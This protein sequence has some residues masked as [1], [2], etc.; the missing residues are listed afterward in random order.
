MDSEVEKAL[1]GIKSAW[2][3]L[4]TA[5]DKDTFDAWSKEQK[6]L[7]SILYREKRKLY[8]H[9]RNT[10]EEFRASRRLSNGDR[11]KAGRPRKYVNLTERQLKTQQYQH[12]YYLRVTKAKRAEKRKNEV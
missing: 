8:I 4:L 7:E 1:A 12:E 11:K 5:K 3:N 10:S 9:F 2:K 6:R